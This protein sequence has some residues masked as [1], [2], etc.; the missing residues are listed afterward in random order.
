M[1]T[2][3]HHEAK[4]LRARTT[5]TYM[6]AVR[7]SEYVWRGVFLAAVQLCADHASSGLGSIAAMAAS[8]ASSNCVRSYGFCKYAENRGVSAAT[9]ST[10]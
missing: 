6:R 5:H 3:L 9:T 8:T 4:L 1:K 2:F 10:L 7:E